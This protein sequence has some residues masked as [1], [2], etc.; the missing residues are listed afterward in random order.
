MISTTKFYGSKP[1]QNDLG[2]IPGLRPFYVSKPTI[3]LLTD[4]TIRRGYGELPVG[5]VLCRTLSA[6]GECVPYTPNDHTAAHSTRM[7]ATANIATGTDVITISEADS[8]KLAVGDNLVIAYDD[9]GLKSVDGGLIISI[10][11]T[12]TT[13][14]VTFTT[15]IPASA[16][17]T[18]ANGVH[19]YVASTATVVAD[20]KNVMPF[21]ITDRPVDTGTGTN[22]LGALVSAVMSNAIL[23]KDMIQEYE[24]AMFTTGLSGFID[25]RHFILR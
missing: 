4:V 5:T 17:F 8:F 23:M 1:Q 10:G 6:N 20:A 25:R 11:A 21:C 12:G 2:Q 19:C 7:F 16:A 14:V 24:A 18:T 15:A 22:A 3:A 9:T 13:R